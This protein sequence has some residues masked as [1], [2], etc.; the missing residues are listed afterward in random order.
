MSKTPAVLRRAPFPRP[1]AARGEVDEGVARA[2]RTK[3]GRPVRARVRRESRL[4]QAEVTHKELTTCPDD[5]RARRERGLTRKTATVNAVGDRVELEYESK[6]NILPSSESVQ[7]G[8]GT[9]PDDW[10]TFTA[11]YD[12]AY[13][14]ITSSVDPNGHSWRMTLDGLGRV[15]ELYDPGGNLPV[16]KFSYTYGTPDNPVSV[17]RVDQLVERSGRY[18]TSWSYSDGAGRTRQQKETAEAPHGYVASAWTELSSRGKP[19][20]IY[21]TF[22]T[23]TLGLE[24]PPGDVPVTFTY[25]DALG[26]PV[27]VQRP[28]TDDLPSGSR[29]LTY[30]QPFETRAYTEKESTLGQLEHPVITRMDGL[31][32]VR[33]VEKYNSVRGEL[34]R[35]RWR[36]GYDTRGS[37]TTFGDPQWNGDLTDQRHLRHYTYDS[38]G[39]LTTVQDPNAGQTDYAFDDLGRVVE[40]VDPLG[41]VQ[42]WYYGRAGRL[43]RH[44]VTGD[45]HGAPDY[46]HLYHYDTLAPSSPLTTAGNSNLRG[47]L[48]WLE[49]PTGEEHYSY[50]ALGR[51]QEEAQRLWNPETS[52]FEVQERDTYHREIDY[53]AD[54][55]VTR[56][57]APGGELPVESGKLPDRADSGSGEVRG[58]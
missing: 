12:L 46:E 29:V 42:K 20:E 30:Y 44:E 57:R 53:R 32:R 38:L 24:E 19:V 39:R 33:E 56:N 28:P 17:T 45:A 26:R 48:S 22:T 58:K 52:S 9:D 40:R 1:R 54:G 34:Q 55:Q 18:H 43:M 13:G 4:A 37:I 50:D 5:R 8:G 6:S 21:D 51:V 23:Q 14:A 49:F 16:S 27:E 2:P 3:S 10:V 15:T 7:V 31:G 41:Q 36:I 47:K 11:Q 25:L 35:L